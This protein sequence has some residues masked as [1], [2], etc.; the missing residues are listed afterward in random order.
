MLIINIAMRLGMAMLWLVVLIPMASAANQDDLQKLRDT[1]S[2]QDCD[3]RG[4]DLREADLIGAN[5]SNAN[6]IRANLSNANLISANLSNAKLNRAVLNDADLSEANLSYADLRDSKF[7]KAIL[8]GANLSYANLRRTDFQNASLEN[9]IMIQAKLMEAKLIDADLYNANLSGA[10]LSNAFLQKADLSEADLDS[11]DLSWAKLDSTNLYQ[12]NL[13]QARLLGAKLTN[14]LYEPKGDPPIIETMWNVEGLYS[15]RWKSSPRGLHALREGFKREG[16]RKQEREITFSIMHSELQNTRGIWSRIQFIL[17]EVT[18][19]FGLSPGRPL[20]I[21][22]ILFL[23]FSVVY[24]V[25]IRSQQKSDSGI[26]KVWGEDR[27]IKR[28]DED[29]PKRLIESKWQ[30]PLWGL[31][32]SLISTFHFGWRDLNIGNWIARINPNEYALRPTGWVKSVSGVQ[33]LIS[34]YLVA[35]SALSY[36]GRPF[37]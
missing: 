29:K 17:F 2:C 16:M 26:W 12:T 1:G 8:N 19:D 22:I 27:I 5:L 7:Q 18:C 20:K 4:A 14:A 24:M 13:S 25:S 3:L 34:V 30:V 6:L 37:G 33:S 23:G 28:D 10:V 36:F 32:Y 11:A 21:L 15:L 9:A 35:L 31:W